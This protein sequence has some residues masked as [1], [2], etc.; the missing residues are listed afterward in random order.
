MEGLH[1]HAQLIWHNSIE[2]DTYNS[3][4]GQT[5]KMDGTKGDIIVGTIFHANGK[6]KDKGCHK[7][8]A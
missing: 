3:S 6:Y 1:L 7:H 8:V 5:G 4:N 2:Q